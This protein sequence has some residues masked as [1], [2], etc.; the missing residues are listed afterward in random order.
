M[1]RAVP[2]R[3][4]PRRVGLPLPPPRR[5]ARLLVRLDPSR[6]GM[7]RFLLEAYENVAYFTVLDRRAALLKIV[8]SPHREAA[9]RAALAEIAASLPLEALPWPTGR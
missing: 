9:A 4:K 1:P 6:V 3:R 5:S 7:F 8:F 2:P